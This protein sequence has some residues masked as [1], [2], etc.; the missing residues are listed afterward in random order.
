MAPLSVQDTIDTT[1]HL[2]WTL[3]GNERLS[4]AARRY[5]AQSHQDGQAYLTYLDFHKVDGLHEPGLGSQHTGIQAAPGCGDD[6]ATSTVDSISMQCHIVD[7]EAY[8]PH[9]LLTQCPL[10]REW[11]KTTV[12]LLPLST[13][14]RQGATHQS[15]N[16]AYASHQVS[17]HRDLACC[18]AR[19]SQGSSP[20]RE[21]HWPHF[22]STETKTGDPEDAPP[23]SLHRC[24]HA[25]AR[26]PL[27]NSDAND[28]SAGQPSAPSPPLWPT[29][30][31]PLRCP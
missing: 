20:R 27:T 24:A 18:L 7:I 5:R 16:P 25:C 26:T 14:A 28:L 22:A 23:T 15:H 30:S 2:L 19:P 1:N 6:L 4:A 29:G 21:N 8:A 13:A 11:A 31:Q 12:K 3:S 10:H 9:V 17:D